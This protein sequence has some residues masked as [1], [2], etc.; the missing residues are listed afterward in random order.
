MIDDLAIEPAG[1]EF[2]PWR[3]LHHGPLSRRTIDKCPGGDL[4]WERYRARNLPLLAKLTRTFGTCAIIAR[5]GDRIVGCLRFYPR[6][7]VEMPG[8]GGLCLLQDHPSGPA[9]GFAAAAFPP[10]DGIRDKTI[11]VHCLMILSP[12]QKRDSFRRR[13]IG[14]RLVRAL[15]R[16]GQDRGWEGLEADAFEDLPVIYETTGSAGHLFWEK[17][18]FTLADRHPHPALQ[19][20]S[21]FAAT[22][23]RQAKA[24]GIDPARARDRLVMRRALT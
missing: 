8:A 18:G 6:A 7:V 12:G 17:L 16:W 5:T 3:C 9:D 13:G 21:A 14:T 11:V 2:L 15:I 4:P 20:P 1:E 24:A 10:L 19:E 22:L 23:E